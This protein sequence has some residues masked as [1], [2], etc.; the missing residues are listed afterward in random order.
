MN[1]GNSLG[2]FRIA[3]LAGCCIP[4]ILLCSC[5][6]KYAASD[7]Y[8]GDTAYTEKVQ[9][10]LQRI[11]DDKMDFP[12]H[13]QY[14]VSKRQLCSQLV[15]RHFQARNRGMSQ[16][17]ADWLMSEDITQ[18]LL[19]EACLKT[20]ANPA[21]FASSDGFNAWKGTHR[22]TWY[23]P[24][25]S[26]WDE[27]VWSDP[28]REPCK[29]AGKQGNDGQPLIC[30]TQKVNWPN[31]KV[32]RFGWHQSH[33]QINYLWGWDPKDIGNENGDIGM[34]IGFPFEFGSCSF[35]IWITPKVAFLEGVNTGKTV[36]ITLKG[37]EVTGYPKT[38]AALTGGCGQWLVG[39]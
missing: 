33:P 34:H 25:Q 32:G 37:T 5:S 7:R 35:I 26:F 18:P 3:L 22:G 1:R 2:P 31:R 8:P 19:E 9:N 13:R 28:T 36:T 16:T 39:R 29:L 12:W 17:N 24:N 38:S 6:T 10:L 20:L 21:G 4:A 11:R 27:A 15:D 30:V 14:G 23:E